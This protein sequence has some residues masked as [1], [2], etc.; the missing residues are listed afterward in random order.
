MWSMEERRA[1]VRCN[2]PAR[3]PSRIKARAGFYLCMCIY[4]YIYSQ[5]NMKS[6]IQDFS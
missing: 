6:R 3:R 1:E 5:T 4:I 2:L